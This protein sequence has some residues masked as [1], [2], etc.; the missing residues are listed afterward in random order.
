M[1]SFT[2]EY[3]AIQNLQYEEI[4]KR[5]YKPR[6]SLINNSMDNLSIM[7][8]FFESVQKQYNDSQFQAIKE[9]CSVKEGIS[10]LQGPVLFTFLAKLQ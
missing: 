10:L 8:K 1:N 4:S 9:I 6:M 2:R 7:C 3:F 5:I